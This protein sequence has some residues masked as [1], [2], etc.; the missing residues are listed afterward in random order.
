MASK[1]CEICGKV[2]ES[3]DFV[4]EVW[5]GERKYIVHRPCLGEVLSQHVF[6]AKA[7]E[8]VG[9]KGETLIE[10]KERLLKRIRIATK[11]ASR[12]SEEL[13]ALVASEVEDGVVDVRGGRASVTAREA[14]EA[15]CASGLVYPSADSEEA[16]SCETCKACEEATET[17]KS[18]GSRAISPMPEGCRC[19]TSGFLTCAKD[20]SFKHWEPKDA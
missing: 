8:D 6:I 16:K 2:F 4:A 1:V 11:V 20:G 12:A 5:D 13:L 9:T 18:R 15:L 10:K 14:N 17:Q 19:S 7:T 3:D